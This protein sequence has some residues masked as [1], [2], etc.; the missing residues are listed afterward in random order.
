[1]THA[2]DLL[3]SE[4]LVHRQETDVKVIAL[5]FFCCFVATKLT[6]NGSCHEVD[7]K[8]AF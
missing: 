8:Q 4:S 2:E 1:M 3:G 6:Y 7:A 5:A